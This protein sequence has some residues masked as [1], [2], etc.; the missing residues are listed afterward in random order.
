MY[1]MT[2]REMTIGSAANIEAIRIGKLLLI[3]IGRNGRHIDFWFPL[4]ISLLRAFLSF[5]Q[6]SVA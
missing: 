5:L 4:L 2:E 3:E 6:H 1:P